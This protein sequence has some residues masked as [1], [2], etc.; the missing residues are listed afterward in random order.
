MTSPT[1]S[2]LSSHLPA[3]ASREVLI[4]YGALTTVDPGDIMETLA[5]CVRDKIRISVVAL[6]AEMKICR[7]LCDRTGG[8]QT[9]TPRTG[10]SADPLYRHIQCSDERRAF[11][12]PCIRPH[13]TTRSARGA[14]AC[15]WYY[16]HTRRWGGFDAHGLSDSLTSGVTGH[17]MCMSRSY[18]TRRFLVSTLSSSPL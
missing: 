1:F 12:R 5:A 10:S 13:T 8:I 6:A 3:H 4:V 9:K 7:E 15:N 14:Q 2:T 17:P 11:Q 18:A 16:W